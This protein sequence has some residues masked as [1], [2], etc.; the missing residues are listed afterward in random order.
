MRGL[1]LKIEI[2]AFS[3][4]RAHE[5]NKRGRG[6]ENILITRKQQLEDYTI[7]NQMP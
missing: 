3:H 7:I 6:R 5:A 1:F 4:K 2:E